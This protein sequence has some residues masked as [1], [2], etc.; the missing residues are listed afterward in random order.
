MRG[1]DRARKQ[2]GDVTHAEEDIATLQAQ[3]EE[4]EASIKAETDSI[5]AA[6]NPAAEK[7]ELLTIRPKKT[8]ITVRVTALAWVAEE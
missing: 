8:G 1:I 2:T 5:A 6:V 7:F 3:K 4:L